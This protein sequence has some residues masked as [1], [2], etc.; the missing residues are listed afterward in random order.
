L[1]SPVKEKENCLT[2]PVLPEEFLCVSASGF[3][4]QTRF[5]SQDAYQAVTLT[6]DLAMF[7]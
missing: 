3:F 5:D 2:H 4:R 6:A 1:T 7:L